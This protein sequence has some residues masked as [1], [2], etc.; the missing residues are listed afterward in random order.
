MAT[1]TK[2][3][4]D[5]LSQQFKEKTQEARAICNKLKEADAWPLDDV[6]LEQVVG[7]FIAGD[8]CEM[9]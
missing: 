1:F 3:Q 9:V 7:G 6:D 8:Q 4:I 2:E 5:Q